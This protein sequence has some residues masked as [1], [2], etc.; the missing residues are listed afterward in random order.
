M[1]GPWALNARHRGRC[2]W[3]WCK[4]QRYGTLICDLERGAVIDL[5]PD[6]EPAIVDAW[7]P[8]HPQTEVFAQDRN[9]GYRKAI[10]EALPDATH[11]A[12]RWHLLQN[13]SD[14]FLAAVRRAIPV[15]RRTTCSA[16]LD[17]GILTAAERLQF[18]GFQ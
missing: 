12:D 11:V 18:K 3:A 14:A 10:S 1:R 6:R 9:G 7:L 16:E 13:A 15:I 17:P 5:L 4:G 2:D 8:Q